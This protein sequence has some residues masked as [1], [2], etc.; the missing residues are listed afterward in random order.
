MQFWLADAWESNWSRRRNAPLDNPRK[1]HG[2]PKSPIVVQD[3]ECVD[4]RPDPAHHDPAH[5]M[6]VTIEDI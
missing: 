1:Q 6:S 2:T 3:V 4:A 5:H